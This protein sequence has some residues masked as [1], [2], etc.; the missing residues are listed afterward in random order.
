[1]TDDLAILLRRFSRQM[2]MLRVLYWLM[3]V[4]VFVLVIG[5]SGADRVTTG[6]LILVAIGLP[7]VI[8]AAASI[9]LSLTRQVQ[10]AAILMNLGKLDDAEVWIKRTLTGFSLSRRAKVTAAQLLASL[11]MLRGRHEAVVAICRALLH[12]PLNRLRHVWVEARLLLA[13]A[14]LLL[15]RLGEAHEALIPV[16]GVP[17]SLGVRMK[18][19][20]IQLRY[21]LA[22]GHSGSAVAALPEKVRIAELMDSTNAALTHALLAEAC[23]RENRVAEQ[24]YLAERARLYGDL[25]PLA[26]RHPVISPIAA[27]P[28]GR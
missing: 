22:A 5:V 17:L 14:L 12:Q 15:G 28:L 7:I 19:L 3:M 1:M 16:Y 27:E 13:D 26:E 25:P 2:L 11:M 10:A 23:R 21:E 24:D 18:L 20:P 4:V 8:V 9:S 6:H